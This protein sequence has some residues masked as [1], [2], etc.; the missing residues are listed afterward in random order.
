MRDRDKARAS[1]S[2]T[3]KERVKARLKE[4]RS[5]NLRNGWLQGAYRLVREETDAP[6]GLSY[7]MN[8]PGSF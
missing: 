1:K 7:F 3:E 6:I 2:N 5:M 4:S 8:L